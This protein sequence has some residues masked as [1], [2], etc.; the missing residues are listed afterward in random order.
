MRYALPDGE[1]ARLP[2]IGVGEAALGSGA[3][4]VHDVA[5]LGVAAEDVGDDFAEGFG[6]E[7]LVDVLD[8]VVYVLFCGAYAAER[9]S[10]VR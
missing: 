8:G 4:G 5:P 7:T 10:L 6:I 2:P 3:V 1:V 9:V